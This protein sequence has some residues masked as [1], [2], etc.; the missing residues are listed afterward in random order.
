MSIGP[1]WVYR[2]MGLKAI[3]K[4]ANTGLKKTQNHDLGSICCHFNTS[5][6]K[7]NE[8]HTNQLWAQ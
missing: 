7:C 1:K 8:I 5:F 4:T 2:A 3:A 6:Q